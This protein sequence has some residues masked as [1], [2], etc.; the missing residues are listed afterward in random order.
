MW[1]IA[2]LQPHDQTENKRRVSTWWTSELAH[3]CDW[4]KKGAFALVWIERRNVTVQ[5]GGGTPVRYEL[6]V[7]LIIACWSV[8]S[9]FVYL[10]FFFSCN[11]QFLQLWVKRAT[12]VGVQL[13]YG[14]KPH[15]RVKIACFTLL[16]IEETLSYQLIGQPRAGS[17]PVENFF[18]PLPPFPS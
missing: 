13:S 5:L 3:R 6:A 7:R 9:F 17:G 2:G 14:V 12:A 11:S 15:L 10:C 18:R 1:P 16:T 4:S 8:F